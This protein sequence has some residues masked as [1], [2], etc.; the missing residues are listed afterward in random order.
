M[1]ER[2]GQFIPQR[3]NIIH[4]MRHPIWRHYDS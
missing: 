1:E 2:L 4:W 3:E